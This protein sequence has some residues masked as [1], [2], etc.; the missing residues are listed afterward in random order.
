MSIR[1]EVAVALSAFG[2]AGSIRG[3]ACAP[4]TALGYRSERTVDA[5]GV[6][7]FTDLL[8]KEKPLTHRQRGLFAP[9]RSAD[10]VFRVTGDETGGRLDPDNVLWEELQ[11]ER[12]KAR[13]GAAFD[14]GDR[15]QRDESLREIS[16]TFEK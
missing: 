6:A 5:G 16:A 3:P 4:F 10:I 8:G 14:T 2:D 15:K 9:W 7:A 12:A 1:D 11:K 13:A